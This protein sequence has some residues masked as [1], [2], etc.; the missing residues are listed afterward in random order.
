MGRE[1]LGSNWMLYVG[2]WW[3]MFV[4]GEIGQAIGADYSWSEAVAGIVSETIYL[5]ISGLIVTWLVPA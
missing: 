3:L 5:P 4:L 2:L 1:A